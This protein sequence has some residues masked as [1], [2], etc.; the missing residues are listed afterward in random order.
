MG[1][2]FAFTVLASLGLAGLQFPD[3]LQR[4]MHLCSLMPLSHNPVD[5]TLIRKF[6]F[7][8]S[9][10]GYSGPPSPN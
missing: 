2:R 8:P 5:P 1:A 10:P 3:L 4:A 6:L 9:R 7:L